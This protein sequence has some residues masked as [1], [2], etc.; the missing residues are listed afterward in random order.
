LGIIRYFKHNILVCALTIISV[1]AILLSFGY[2]FPVLFDLFFYHFPRFSSFR[3]PVMALVLVHFAMPILAAFG[4][5]AIIEMRNNFGTFK[6]LPK[7]EKTP[8]LSFFVIVGIFILGGLFF[9]NVYEENY[10]AAVKNA[11]A[12]QQYGEQVLTALAPFIFDNA[13]SD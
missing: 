13:V 2:T 1:F 8:L 12:L 6:A 5:K 4:I 11:P 3:A 9:A 10:I 7:E